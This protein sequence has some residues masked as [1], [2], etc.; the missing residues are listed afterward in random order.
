MY[1]RNLFLLPFLVVVIVE[2]DD[3]FVKMG[4][5]GKSGTFIMLSVNNRKRGEELI[6]TW[7]WM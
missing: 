3:K 2:R 5:G 4:W 1:M 7:I 6:T